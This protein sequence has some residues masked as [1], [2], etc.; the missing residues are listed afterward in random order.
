MEPRFFYE[1][2]VC[3]ETDLWR[4]MVLTTKNV[5]EVYLSVKIQTA[6]LIFNLHMIL[7][8]CY[9]DNIS[10]S[11]YTDKDTDSNRERSPGSW[12]L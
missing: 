10:T 5:C 8:Y 12:S 1:A 3:G 6:K 9:F 4:D 7:L 2:M 11:M